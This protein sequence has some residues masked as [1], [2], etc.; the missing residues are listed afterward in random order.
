MD[1]LQND[2]GV[3]QYIFDM[4]VCFQDVLKTS[5]LDVSTSVQYIV[6]CNV[7]DVLKMSQK[8]FF[9]FVRCKSYIF[10]TSFMYVMNVLRM[11]QKHLEFDWCNSYIFGTSFVYVL[12]VLKTYKSVMYFFYYISLYTSPKNFFQTFY[13][14]SKRCFVNFCLIFPCLIVDSM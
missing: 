8:H 5:V 7:I 14:A 12:N 6:S 11:S 10:R 13:I 4:F 3:P 9:L 2:P 1:S